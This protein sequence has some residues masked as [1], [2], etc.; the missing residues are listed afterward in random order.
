VGA[1]TNFSTF[2]EFPTGLPPYLSVSVRSV[3]KRACAILTSGAPALPLLVYQR[4]PWRR[5][6]GWG[7][8]LGRDGHEGRHA[9]LHLRLD[10]GH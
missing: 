3:C 7:S 6:V 2:I 1:S 4:D 10:V 8:H 9:M 5:F